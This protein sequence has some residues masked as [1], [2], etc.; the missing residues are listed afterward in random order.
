MIET[1]TKKQ[2]RVQHICAHV[3][4]YVLL[5]AVAVAVLFPFYFMV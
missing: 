4:L 3:L 2:F 5:V 1:A